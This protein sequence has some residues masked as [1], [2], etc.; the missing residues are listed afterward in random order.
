V[1]SLRTGNDCACFPASTVIVLTHVV[2]SCAEPP[3]S[4]MVHPT[5]PA[6]SAPRK[7]TRSQ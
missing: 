4:Q 6:T 7:S 3:K 1:R 5:S 2:C